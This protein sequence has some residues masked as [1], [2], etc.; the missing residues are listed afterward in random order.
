MSPDNGSRWRFSLLA[1][2]LTSS[3]NISMNKVSAS[4]PWAVVYT[5]VFLTA[6]T[7]GVG[8]VPKGTKLAEA[9]PSVLLFLAVTATALA[10]IMPP[11]WKG[12]VTMTSAGLIALFVIASENR[13]VALAALAGVGLVAFGLVGL[14]GVGMSG[15]SEHVGAAY[16]GMCA[17]TM[18]LFLLRFRGEL[19]SGPARVT[20]EKLRESPEPTWLGGLTLGFWVVA[21]GVSA[22]NDR[23]L[24]AAVPLEIGSL[25][26]MGV[27]LV[28]C[29]SQ[30]G[31]R[32][33]ALAGAL[34]AL[35]G[36]SVFALGLQWSSAPVLGSIVVAA[37]V[38]LAGSGL[39]LL[40]STGAITAAHRWLTD[41]V[42]P[43][44]LD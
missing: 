19:F 22:A 33:D 12:S 6:V 3:L 17:M 26:W 7:I 28:F 13:A 14:V 34:A 8:R 11:S 20:M 30:A 9:L 10:M 44:P 23:M 37:G 31:K 27:M 32:Q 41:L 16:V 18:G 4:V 21:Y 38:V 25:S 40:D 2:I 1:L 36:A 24:L 5:V 35:C 42:T 29:I 15:I 43:R 39:S